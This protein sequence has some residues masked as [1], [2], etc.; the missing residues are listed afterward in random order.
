MEFNPYYYINKPENGR[1]L[2]TTD[3]HGCFDTFNELLNKIG[4]NKNDQ[5][6]ILGDMIDRGKKSR[7]LLDKIIDLRKNNY[8]ILPLRG[9]HEEMVWL[10]HLK[11]YDEKTL[12]L[13]GYKWGKDITD[14]KRN[15]LPEYIDFIKM[16]PYYYEL[17]NFYLVHAG[18]DFS[19]PTPFN[20]YKS[21]VWVNEPV[22]DKKIT[23][24]KTILHGHTSRSINTIK[25]SLFESWT[26]IGI[27]NYIMKKGNPQFGNLVCLN[28]DSLELTIQANIDNK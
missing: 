24:N 20:D 11:D 4:L 26:F 1:R 2:A 13:P 25:E 3:I 6:F 15:I 10:A 21:M 9:N 22:T 18:F 12:K 16:L 23:N 8:N 27:D 28:I 17:E 19:N 14:S 5:L 7:E